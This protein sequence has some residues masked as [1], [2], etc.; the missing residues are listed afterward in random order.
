MTF[1]SVIRIDFEGFRL[2]PPVDVVV[3][4]HLREGF[5]TPFV[6]SPQ[7]LEGLL[8]LDRHGVVEDRIDGAVAKNHEPAHEHQPQV[9]ESLLDEGVVD[10]V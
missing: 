5:S 2:E 7:L 6:A 10:H 1:A 9:F 3:N 4:P 8:E